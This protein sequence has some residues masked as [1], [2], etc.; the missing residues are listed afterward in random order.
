MWLGSTLQEGLRHENSFVK[1]RIL[2]VEKLP[3]TGGKMLYNGSWEEAE[4]YMAI[5]GF[6]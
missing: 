4:T 3:H 6:G 5:A 1:Q 2:K